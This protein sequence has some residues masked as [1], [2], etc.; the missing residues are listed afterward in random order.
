MLETIDEI[1][2]LKQSEN[3]F[4]INYFDCFKENYRA[5]L[6]TFYCEDGDLNDLIE[7]NKKMNL[8]IQEECIFEWTCQML[9][10]L[11]YLHNKNIIHRDIKPA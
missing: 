11:S 9:K 2:I 10:G 3:A 1:N 5:C 7:R 4:I 6:V 8:F